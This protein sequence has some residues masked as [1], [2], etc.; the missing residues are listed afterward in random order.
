MRSL[1]RSVGVVLQDAVIFPGTV[2]ENIAY[3]HGD[4]TPEEIRWAARWA[5]A[6]DFIERLPNGYETEAGDEGGLLSG[7]QRQRIAIARA[8]VA[9]PS[10]LIFDEPTTHLD[11]ASIRLLLA[12]LV[13]YPG[14]PTVIL[15]S[16]DSEVANHVDAV[17]YL[18][19]GRIVKTD[20]IDAPA[21]V[22]S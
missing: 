18:R 9:R 17:H 6:D 2:A 16:H 11:D 14:A 15:I 22:S 3:G 7:G 20:R 19:D 13:D 12:N 21:A 8:L 1:R 10:V 4:A 5:T